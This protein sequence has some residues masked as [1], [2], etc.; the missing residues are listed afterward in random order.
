MQTFYDFTPYNYTH[1]TAANK[2]HDIHAFQAIGGIN[3]MML[4]IKKSYTNVKLRQ[5]TL[6][7]SSLHRD[8]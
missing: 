3:T 4:Y 6:V 5:F 1:S 2:I 7:G 8:L